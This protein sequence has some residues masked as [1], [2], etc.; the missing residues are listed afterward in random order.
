MAVRIDPDNYNIDEEAFHLRDL[1]Q[2]I[3]DRT[4]TIF[5]SYGVPLPA[6]RY[7]TMG[8]PALDC[9]QLVIA[10]VQMYLGAPG[11]EAAEPQRCNVPRSAVV[12]VNL[13]RAIP[14]VGQTGRAPEGQKI[15]DGSEIVA[16]DSWIMMESIKLFDQWDEMG[17]GPGVIATLNMSEAQGGFQTST[18]QLTMMVP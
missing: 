5:Q 6:R 18:L 16:V 7:W 11:D 3:L 17:F 10:F 14:S 1:M 8:Q 13:S 2:G 4:V 9:E 15:Q 12:T